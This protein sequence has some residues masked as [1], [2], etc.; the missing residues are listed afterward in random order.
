MQRTAI[1]VLTLASTVLL[2]SMA[3]GG[4]VA[5]RAFV[6]ASLAF[7][8][9][10]ILLAGRPR[11]RPWR[12]LVPAGI[13]AVLEISGLLVLEAGAAVST[14]AMLGGLCLV[15]LVVVPWLHALTERPPS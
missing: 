11:R 13:T 10:L 5:E 4:P 6:V 15:P 3:L 1:A 12:W 7:P 14:L 2:L 9:A 8:G